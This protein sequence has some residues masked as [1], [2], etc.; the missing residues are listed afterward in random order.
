MP[1]SPYCHFERKREIFFVCGQA[2]DVRIAASGKHRAP[3]ESE[4]RCFMQT[5]LRKKTET[6]NEK[7][8]SAALGMTKRG[9]ASFHSFSTCCGSQ[10]RLAA[11]GSPF[12]GKGLAWILPPSYGR[13]GECRLTDFPQRRLTIR[14][15]RFPHIVISSE[16]EKIFFVCGQAKDVRI[17]ASWKHRASSESE[18]RC[19]M[20]TALRRKTETGNEKD[21]SAA[22]GMTKRWKRL[23]SFLFNLLRKPTPPRCARQPLPREGARVDTPSFLWKEV[24]RRGGGW[25]GKALSPTQ[26]LSQWGRLRYEDAAFLDTTPSPMGKAKRRRLR[27]KKESQPRLAALGSPFQGKGLAWTLPLSNGEGCDTRTP[28]SPFCRIFG[29]SVSFFLVDFVHEFISAGEGDKVHLEE[30]GELVPEVGNHG[31]DVRG[32]DDIVHLPEGVIAGEGLF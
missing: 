12:Q 16:S 30:A 10:P 5:A 24:P 20:Q 31:G 14:E 2:K 8:P 13:G 9:N 15:C 21:P 7:D 19:F 25:M 28:L 11:L 23:F 6:G 4:G 17:A 22:L 32:H 27:R 26:S 3:S 18:G 29:M 1:L